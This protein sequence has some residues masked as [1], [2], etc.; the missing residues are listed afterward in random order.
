MKKRKNDN[1]I[2]LDD[3]IDRAESPLKERSEL[4][5]VMES[6]DSDKIDQDTQMSGI[7]MNTRLSSRQIVSVLVFD[8][9][10][11]KGIFDKNCSITRQLKRLSISK[12]GEG[13]R[14]KVEIVKGERQNQSGNSFGERFLGMFKRKE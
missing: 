3:I 5:E 14:E 11:R 10:Q 7:D 2:D 4:G 13:R 9:L 6:L 1:S 12:N 8:E